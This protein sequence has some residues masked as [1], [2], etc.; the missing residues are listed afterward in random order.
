MRDD[1]HQDL[2]KV[3]NDFAS[4]DGFHETAIP[5]IHCIK[6]ASPRARARTTWR[7]SF[8]IV[9]Q[10][11]KEITL[12]SKVFRYAGPHYIVSAVDLPV[13]SSIPAASK[14]EPFLAIRVLIDPSELNQIASRMQLE[15]GHEPPARFD[16][17]SHGLFTGVAHSD[18]L[19][20][21]IRL[22]KLFDK[23]V[24]AKILGPMIVQE[25]F[26]HLLWKR[27]RS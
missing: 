20:C 2:I 21:L 24:D 7:S 22:A 4:L 9:I 18:L 17:K 26:Y 16:M 6:F 1:I 12:E 23:P 15:K 13:S 19:D 5:H 8:V 11:H 3:I 10:G 25:M 14:E 27:G